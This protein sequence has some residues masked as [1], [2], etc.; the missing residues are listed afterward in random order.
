MSR[1]HMQF[2]YHE[3]NLFLT[4]YVIMYDMHDMCNMN[5][6]MALVRSVRLHLNRITATQTDEIRYISVVYWGSSTGGGVWLK[7]LSWGQRAERTGIWWWWLPSQ[8]F[9]LICKW[10]NPLF[11]L[12]CYGCI[13]HGTGNSTRLCQ[14]FRIS[15]SEVEPPNPP[16]YANYPY[17]SLFKSTTYKFEKSIISILWMHK[18]LK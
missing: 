18:T 3:N 2:M 15:G 11:L 13:F 1:G 6:Y 12:D 10:V 7:K 4:I 8:G 17:A 14:N 16:W 9:R 5:R